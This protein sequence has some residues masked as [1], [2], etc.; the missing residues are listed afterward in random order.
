MFEQ[1]KGFSRGR[2]KSHN[3]G[4]DIGGKKGG[5]GKGEKVKGERR[6]GSSLPWQWVFSGF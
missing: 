3:G 4:G 5:K 6:E 1:D 2:S